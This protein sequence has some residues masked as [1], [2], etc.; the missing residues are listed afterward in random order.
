MSGHDDSSQCWAK[1]LILTNNRIYSG[2]ENAPN[3]ED[4]IYLGFENGPNISTIALAL[5]GPN[6]LNSSNSKRIV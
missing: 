3:T 4:R 5:F 1:N 2:S 6:Y